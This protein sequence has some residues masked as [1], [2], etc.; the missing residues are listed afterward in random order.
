MFHVWGAQ[1]LKALSLKSVQAWSSI[2]INHC[3][4]LS[5]FSQLKEVVFKER[6]TPNKTDQHNL[7]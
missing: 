6:S 2:K 4:H 1:Y 3:V 5:N 7:I